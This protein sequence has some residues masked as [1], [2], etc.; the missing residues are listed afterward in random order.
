MALSPF[1]P[2]RARRRRPSGARGRH[3]DRPVRL[4]A[5][6]ALHGRG[7]PLLSPGEA[8]LIAS[9]N[10]AGYLLGALARR[11]ALPEGLAPLLAPGGPRRQRR[12]DAPRAGQRRR[13]GPRGDPVRGRGRERPRPRLRLLGRAGAAC[14]GRREP[15][16]GRPFRGRRRGDPRVEPSSCPRLRPPASAGAPNGSPR[17]SR[18]SRPCRLWRPSFRRTRAGAGRRAPPAGMRVS[19]RL[20]TLIAS[21]GLFGFGYVIT[22]TFLVAIVRGSPAIRPLEPVDLGPVRPRGDP[23]GRP[24]VGP[25]PA[26]RDLRRLFAAPAS[27]KRPEWRRACSSR[28]P[29]A[30]SWLPLFLGGTFIGLTA[31][32]LV[33]ARAPDRLRSAPGPCLDDRRLRARPD[34][35]PR[36]SRARCST[37]PAASRRRRSSRPLALVAAA[38]LTGG[39]ARRT[40]R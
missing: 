3:G 9:A 23:V 35:R 33:G 5:D 12:H 37:G 32:G 17:D 34:R 25:R 36:P 40:G 18:D 21:Y 4:H 7:H 29:S 39:L 15:P 1:R 10:F 31:L 24:V 38:A 20:A 28:T 16:V 13:S 14:R 26:H 11:D 8:G 19:P 6:P 2:W 27:S 22:A 30:P